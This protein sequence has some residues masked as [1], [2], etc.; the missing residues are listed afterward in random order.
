[1]TILSLDIICMWKEPL[2][3][4]MHR[5]GRFPLNAVKRKI[6]SVLQMFQSKL[7]T[8]CKL[9]VLFDCVC[10][11][12]LVKKRLTP[13]GGGF[14]AF[15]WPSEWPRTWKRPSPWLSK[16]V[17]FT[18]YLLTSAH[19]LPT[20]WFGSCPGRK[21][22][23]LVVRCACGPWSGHRSSVS[24]HK[25]WNVLLTEILWNKLLQTFFFPF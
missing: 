25:V 9:L 4:E 6:E 13:T 10:P 24:H 1:M 5:K 18:T 11:S 22:P 8:K 20:G 16:G 21:T 12:V 15:C 23:S 17:S 2:A 7:K 14:P 3:N 19:L